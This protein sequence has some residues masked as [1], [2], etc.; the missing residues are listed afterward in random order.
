MLSFLLS[1]SKG[2]EE[3]VDG[4]E[5]RVV[6]ARRVERESLILVVEDGFQ[7]LKDG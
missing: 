3:A 7:R 6:A 1:R 5:R 4:E 2:T